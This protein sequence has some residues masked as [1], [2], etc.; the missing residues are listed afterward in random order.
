[1]KALSVRGDY[2]M[3]MINGHKKVE[4]RTWK[5]NYRGP[6]LMCSTTKKVA[7][8]A[9]GYALCIMNLEQITWSDIDQCYYWYIN[10]K[11]VIEP[12]H[13][14]GQLKLFSVEDNLIKP[15]SHQKFDQKIKSLIYQP[16]RK[17]KYL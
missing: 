14:K 17:M 4:Y 11:S 12:I 1:M 15:I 6:I 9:P 7:G 2:V 3:E 16:K 5:T 8:A 13:V 10:L